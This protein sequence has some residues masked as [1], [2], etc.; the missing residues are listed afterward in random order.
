[1]VDRRLHIVVVSEVVLKPILSTVGE[2]PFVPFSHL[3]VLSACPRLI[4]RAKLQPR[5]RVRD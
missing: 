5:V 1:M 4:G 3:V 2:R